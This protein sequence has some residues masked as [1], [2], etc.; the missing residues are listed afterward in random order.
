MDEESGLKREEEEEEEEEGGQ[1][2]LAR[3]TLLLSCS[4]FLRICTGCLV[5]II[6]Q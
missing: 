1:K 5:C 3:E 2:R 6:I 4:G